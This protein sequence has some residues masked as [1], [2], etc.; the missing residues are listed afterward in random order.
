MLILVHLLRMEAVML[1]WS[2]FNYERARARSEHFAYYGSRIVLRLVSMALGVHIERVA[3]AEPLPQKTIFV[4]N[5]QSY[6]DIVLILSFSRA[7]RMRFVAKKSLARGFP[8]VSRLMR[9]QGHA[10]IERDAHLL[11]TMRTLHSFARTMADD[12]SPVIFPEGTRAVDGR[13]LPF[14]AAGL[15]QMV[16]NTE[17]SISAL[18][19]EDSYQLNDLFRLRAPKRGSRIRIHLLEHIRAPIAKSDIRAVIS[20]LEAR[21]RRA[22]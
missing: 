6:F 4:S 19:I 9:L 1:F 15:Q 16:K 14:L 5:H 13:L 22:L 8:A 7:H 17:R 20:D 3:P 21:Y 12:I 10:F 11:T 18:I 2:L